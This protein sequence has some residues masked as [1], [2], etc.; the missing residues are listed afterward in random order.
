MS[1]IFSFWI[2]DKVITDN[3]LTSQQTEGSNN[4]KTYP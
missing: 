1:L 2:V 4:V 3:K